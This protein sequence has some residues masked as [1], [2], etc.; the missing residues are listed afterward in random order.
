LTFCG[1]GENG[2]RQTVEEAKEVLSQLNHILATEP[3]TADQRREFERRAARLAGVIMQ[4]AA[5]PI[6]GVR[7]FLS[8]LIATTMIVGGLYLL[9]GITLTMHPKASAVA[10]AGSVFLIVLG[11][12]LLW[13]DIFAPLL[14]IKA[15]ED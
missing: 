12:Y 10:G 6:T 13:T 4:G 7:K 9:A 8:F 11:A 2:Q 15:A 1:G 5:R 3:L 14:G